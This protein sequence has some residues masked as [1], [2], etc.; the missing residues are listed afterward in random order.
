MEVQASA[1]VMAVVDVGGAAQPLVDLDQLA[2]ALHLEVVILGKMCGKIVKNCNQSYLEELNFFLLI[3]N[4]F[5]QISL[6]L[7]NP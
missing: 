1:E 4:I 7:K 2:V 3:F 5:Y 6:F